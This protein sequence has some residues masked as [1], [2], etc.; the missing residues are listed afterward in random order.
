MKKQAKQREPKFV[1]ANLHV[2]QCQGSGVWADY[3]S[4][5]TAD[6]MRHAVASVKNNSG[7]SVLFRIVK[8]HMGTEVVYS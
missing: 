7:H 2:L 4:I 1:E 3:Y 5:K 6:D 8:K